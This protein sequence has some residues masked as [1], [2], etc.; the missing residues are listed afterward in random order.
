[1]S[2]HHHRPAK[3]TINCPMAI[4]FMDRALLKPPRATSLVIN[5]IVLIDRT[6]AW[7]SLRLG[8]GNP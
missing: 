4:P 6:E 8:R 5:T 3:A 1:M 7:V 2:H